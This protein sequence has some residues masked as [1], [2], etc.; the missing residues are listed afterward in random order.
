[1][2]SMSSHAAAVPGMGIVAAFFKS[3]QKNQKILLRFGL[4]MTLY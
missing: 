1:M 3:S 2:I 4:K